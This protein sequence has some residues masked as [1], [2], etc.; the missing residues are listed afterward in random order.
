M[1]LEPVDLGLE[2]IEASDDAELEKIWGRKRHL[3]KLGRK[4]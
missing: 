4:L 2:L 1:S 3:E